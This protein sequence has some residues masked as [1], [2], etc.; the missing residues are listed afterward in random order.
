MVILKSIMVGIATMVSAII[1]S[2]IAV[3]MVLMFNSRDLPNGQSV[4]WDPISLS[5]AWL[6]MLISFALGSFVLGFWWE[7][8][9]AKPR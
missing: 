8:R 4:Q 9:K 3:I 6:I 7:Y 2:G 1:C 5:R